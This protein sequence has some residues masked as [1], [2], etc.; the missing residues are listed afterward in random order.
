M[1]ISLWLFGVQVMCLTI[2]PTAADEDGAE[3]AGG[4]LASTPISF[5]S[6]LEIPD[7]CAGLD[8]SNGWGDEGNRL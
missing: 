7:D 1:N 3:L 6:A 4:T 2:G 8:R 5:V